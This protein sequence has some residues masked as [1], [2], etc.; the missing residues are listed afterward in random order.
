MWKPSR[1]WGELPKPARDDPG[2]GEFPSSD[3]STETGPSFVEA[4]DGFALPAG[5]PSQTAVVDRGWG[6]A[7]LQTPWLLPLPGAGIGSYIP[8]PPL[9]VF[10]DAPSAAPFMEP[11]RGTG[12]TLAPGFGMGFGSMPLFGPASQAAAA[13]NR[14]TNPVDTLGEGRPMQNTASVIGSGTLGAESFLTDIASFLGD[15]GNVVTAGQ[16]AFAEGATASVSPAQ[17]D[18]LQSTRE[19]FGMGPEAP[20]PQQGPP[21]AP[22]RAGFNPL[23]LALGG[24][25]LLFLMNRK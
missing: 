16:K 14:S 8:P 7:A 21:P 6:G 9:E 1:L 12:G 25:G 18:I 5:A 22:A 19:A 13:R 3:M 11:D 2:R 17:F 4:A 20:A 24:V 10:P 23:W 15:V